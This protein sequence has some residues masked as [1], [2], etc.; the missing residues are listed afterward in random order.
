MSSFNLQNI[1]TLNN[2]YSA[3]S[4]SSG[5]VQNDIPNDIPV[6]ITNIVKSLTNNILY[7][8]RGWYNKSKYIIKYLNN[9]TSRCFQCY[10]IIEYANIEY[11]KIFTINETKISKPYSAIG[12]ITGIGI[13]NIIC[14]C[15]LCCENNNKQCIIP[16]IAP[17]TYSDVLADYIIYDRSDLIAC[18]IGI[19]HTMQMD[20]IL[21]K[22]NYLQFN[23]NEKT[24]ILNNLINENDK[25]SNNIDLEIE[26]YKILSVQRTKNKD[27]CDK[28]KQQL[29]QFTNELSIENTKIIDNQI[30]KYNELNNSSKYASPE[31][32]ICMMREVKIAIQCGHVFCIECYNILLQNTPLNIDNLN[33]SISIIS[34]PSIYC[35][36]CRTKSCTYTQLYF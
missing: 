14:L 3:L 35:P 24:V 36:T 12:N 33:S 32:K 5:S 25:L 30:N 20:I 15:T 28:I 10:N 23:L 17:K 6:D 31:C 27:I 34:T 18:D 7:K 9:N 16:K 29:I 4:N 13:D 22:I 8:N 11:S 19:I 26:K 2:V 21:K 1:Y